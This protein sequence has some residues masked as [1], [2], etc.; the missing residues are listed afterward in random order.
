MAVGAGGAHPL[1]ADDVWLRWMWRQV[2]REGVGTGNAAVWKTIPMGPTHR[3]QG[4]RGRQFGHPGHLGRMAE[5]WPRRSDFAE[6]PAGA[7]CTTPS[8]PRRPPQRRRDAQTASM[9]RT[10]PQPAEDG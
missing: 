1:R 3:P 6:D 2:I 9:I 10:V 5:I 8:S 7:V 4:D